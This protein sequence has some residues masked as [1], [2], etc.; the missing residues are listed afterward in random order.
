MSIERT[1]A[2]I[3]Q[4]IGKL[5]LFHMQSCWTRGIRYWHEILPNTLLYGYVL[6]QPIRQSNFYG[7]S[8]VLS[9]HGLSVIN[10]LQTSLSDVNGYFT[11]MTHMWRTF[12]CIL[13]EG[14]GWKIY[15]QSICWF[16]CSLF[17]KRD[18]SWLEQHVT[19]Y[20][21]VKRWSISCF[22]IK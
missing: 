22:T 21:E 4:E 1:I 15:I 14:S 17:I 2:V 20:K 19:S 5:K 3:T 6:L 16:L 11:S 10:I 7:S 9:Y 8:S 18:T 13:L 12:C